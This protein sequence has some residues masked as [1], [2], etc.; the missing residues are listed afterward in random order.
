MKCH[1]N[2]FR[3]AT[4]SIAAEHEAS[5]SEEAERHACA[6]QKSTSKENPAPSV[7][8]D[9]EAMTPAFWYSPTRFSKKLVFPCREISSIQSNGLEDV[10][11]FGCPKDTS[12]RSATNSMYLVMRSLFIP[13]RS[14]GNASQMNR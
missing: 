3:T 9:V 1:A 2:E 6:H 12:N 4:L 11:I 7:F 10:K 8:S 5:T 13:I 14:Q